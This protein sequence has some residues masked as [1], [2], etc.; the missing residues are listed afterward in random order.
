MI[1]EDYTNNMSEYRKGNVFSYLNFDNEQVSPF[2]DN[3]SK[4]FGE[5]GVVIG[6]STLHTFFGSV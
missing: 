1:E 5:Y 6:L 2:A 3:M 4:E